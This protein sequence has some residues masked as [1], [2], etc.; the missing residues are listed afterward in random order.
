MRFLRKTVL[1]VV[2]IVMAVAF[3][4]CSAGKDPVAELANDYSGRLQEWLGVSADDVQTMDASDIPNANAYEGTFYLC[5]ERDMPSLDCRTYDDPDKA[6]EEFER[7]YDSF[8]ESFDE[9]SYEGEYQC[10]YE[11][12]YGYIVLDGSFPGVGI[13]GDV[14][15]MGNEIYAGVY[16][17]GNAVAVIMPRNSLNNSD[18]EDV[19][20]RLELPMANG[21]NT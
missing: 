20:S 17:S 4:S 19:I 5:T 15:R 11:D 13:F 3:V 1:T 7:M 12:D 9:D 16:Y 10:F 14:Y 8:N 18:V 2:C 6:R 21:N